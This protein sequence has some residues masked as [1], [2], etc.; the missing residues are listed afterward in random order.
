MNSI[1][2]KIL[3]M[4]ELGEAEIYSKKCFRQS[5]TKVPSRYQNPRRE[6]GAT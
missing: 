4:N 2:S 6:I 5:T 3:L 1:K